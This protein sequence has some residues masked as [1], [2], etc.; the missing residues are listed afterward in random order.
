MAYNNYEGF[1]H[2]KFI[3]SQRLISS[4]QGLFHD[5]IDLGYVT[6]HPTV[7][8]RLETSYNWGQTTF[9][10]MYPINPP[11]PTSHYLGN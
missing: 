6:Q 9:E 7:C 5:E 3:F 8:D 1:P 2:L 11:M 4:L 10:L